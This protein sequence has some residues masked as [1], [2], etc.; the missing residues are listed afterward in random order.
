MNLNPAICFGLYTQLGD[1][2]FLVRRSQDSDLAPI[3]KEL[4]KLES[5][6]KRSIAIILDG[7]KI[8]IL[9]SSNKEAAVAQL[10][11]ESEANSRI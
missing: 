9:R 11:I 5:L 8:A 6:M 3:E 2:R 4:R 7:R 1:G 10:C